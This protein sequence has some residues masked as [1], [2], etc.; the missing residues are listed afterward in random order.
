MTTSDEPPTHAGCSVLS[1]WIG[2]G[3]IISREYSET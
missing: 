2:E 3:G 1:E